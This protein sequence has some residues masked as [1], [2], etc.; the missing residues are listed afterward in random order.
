M[1][2]ISALLLLFGME[3]PL[4]LITNFTA[5]PTEVES[6]H[7][8]LLRWHVKGA[9]HLRLEPCGVGVTRHDGYVDRPTTTTTYTLVA[10]N[11]W[12][13]DRYSVTVPVYAF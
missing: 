2:L 10:K 3:P 4:P 7:S 12:G 9:D 11:R 8:V 1:R 5:T 13:T 6:G